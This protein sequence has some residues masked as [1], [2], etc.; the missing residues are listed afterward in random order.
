MA[1]GR[2]PETGEDLCSQPTLSRLENKTGRIARSAARPAFTGGI[3]QPGEVH[4]VRHGPAVSIRSADHEQETYQDSQAEVSRSAD[5]NVG[6]GAS[7]AA[8]AVADEI[9]ARGGRANA[10]NAD[11]ADAKACA[12]V[13]ADVVA[14]HGRVDILANNAGINRRGNLL[15]ITEE[16]WDYRSSGCRIGIVTLTDWGGVW[17]LG[18][19]GLAACAATVFG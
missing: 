6:C 18:R 17:C 4:R 11:I 19:A 9:V 12:A 8:S 7:N 16:D 2:L 5:K 10:V 13:V 1:V 15:S 14:Q 3:Q